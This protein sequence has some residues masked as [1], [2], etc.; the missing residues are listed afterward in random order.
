M[1]ALSFDIETIELQVVPFA[2]ITKRFH[3]F[4]LMSATILMIVAQCT[5]KKEKKNKVHALPNGGEISE[6]K[7]EYKTVSKYFVDQGQ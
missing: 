2:L 4:R 3:R 5:L 6:D 1:Y 7:V